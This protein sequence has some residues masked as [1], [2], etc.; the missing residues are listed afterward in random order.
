MSWLQFTIASPASLVD[1]QGCPLV[2]VGSHYSLMDVSKLPRL[3]KTTHA[4]RARATPRSLPRPPRQSISRFFIR[5]PRHRRRSM[6]FRGRRDRRHAAWVRFRAWAFARLRAELFTPAHWQPG[7]FAG[8]EVA[9][10]DLEGFKALQDMA[11]FLF[12]VSMMLE[13]AV[14]ADHSSPAAFQAASAWI[15][16]CHHAHRDGAESPALHQAALEQESPP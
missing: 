4:R 9:Y 1:L 8:Q 5:T 13:A 15:R 3:S 16:I 2:R 7:P 10:W 6:A 14:L 11:F 12:G